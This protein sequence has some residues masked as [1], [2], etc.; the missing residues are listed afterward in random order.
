M[1]FLIKNATL[2]SGK[3]G[4]TTADV[5]IEDGI[6]K[7]VD[8]GI[9]A[10]AR[11]IDGSGCLVSP[12]LF[13]LHVHLRVPG[14]EHKEDLQSGLRAA[15]K[16]GFTGVLAMAN[17]VPPIDNPELLQS[18]LADEAV[19]RYAALFQSAALTVG[20][21]GRKI[22]PFENLKKAGAAAF[23][24]DGR[25]V[26]SSRVMYEAMS[27]AARSG[28]P[29]LVH[30]E[31]PE[32]SSGSG[33]SY[34]FKDIKGVPAEAETVP[35]VRDLVLAAQTG[36]RLHVQHLSSGL[37]ISWLRRM[38]PDSGVTVEVT[39]HHLLFSVSADTPPDTLFKVNPPIRS[40]VDRQELIQ[41][42]NEGLVDVIATDHAPHTDEEKNR[43]FSAAPAGM[44]WLE[45]AFPALYT[46]LVLKNLVS[47]ERLLEAMAAAPRKVL[48]LKVPVIEEGERAELVVFNLSQAQTASSR[49]LESKSRNNPLLNTELYGFANYVFFRGT[50]LVEE[51]VVVA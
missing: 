21:E 40:E 27:G 43:D 33:W 9:A 47:L 6:I 50:V 23:S 31:D 29:V 4:L 44:N 7:R 42:L 51:G 8:R 14:E 15:L 28:M 20:L 12:G 38:K 24:D 13:D 16:G 5:L 1:K 2:W 11:V 34:D 18:V 19:K 32:L 25:C 30:E 49:G 26:S 3:A 22:T 46:N 10:D 17:T 45:V 36:S 37:S 35:L 41:A 39:P 48:G